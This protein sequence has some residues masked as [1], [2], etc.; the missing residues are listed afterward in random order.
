MEDKQYQSDISLDKKTKERLTLI[1]ICIILLVL[2]LIFISQGGIAESI[3][4]L[5]FGIPHYIVITVAIFG[6]VFIVFAITNP[7]HAII[8]LLFLRPLMDLPKLFGFAGG[9]GINIAGAVSV[10]LIFFAAI[11]LMMRGI[12]RTQKSLTITYIVFMIICVLSSGQGMIYQQISSIA[13]IFRFLS[14]FIVFLIIINVF[15][16]QHQLEAFRKVVLFSGLIPVVSAPILHYVL[17]VGTAYGRLSGTFVHPNNFAGFLVIISM[18]AFS[19]MIRVKM[20]RAKIFYGFYVVSALVALV[21][22]YSRG[23]WLSIIGAL[24]LFGLFRYRR[25]VIILPIVV[26]AAYFFIHPIQDRMAKAFETRIGY[27]SSWAIRLKIVEEM[28][29]AFL[30]KPLFGHG[31]S[32]FEMLMMRTKVG[33]VQAHNDYL[34]ML[35]EVGIVGL[36]L[37]VIIIVIQVGT[38]IRIYR[39]TND[40]RLK[41]YCILYLS[42]IL[43]FAVWSWKANIFFLPVLM[44]YVWAIYAICYKRYLIEQKERHAPMIDSSQSASGNETPEKDNVKSGNRS[45][46]PPRRSLPRKPNS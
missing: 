22:T 26:A 31:L 37:Y 33:F 27:Q 44:W 32:S 13:D 28:W 3:S 14:Y 30:E 10:A 19:E 38:A 8:L 4:I 43:G 39:H 1:G 12:T 16:T 46:L 9:A 45:Y 42:I 15:K 5:A 11:L 36:A 17:H 21:L 2:T 29:P 24:M 34:A 6:I 25:L 20:F 7:Q 23:G 18:L 35:V 40:Q 41:D